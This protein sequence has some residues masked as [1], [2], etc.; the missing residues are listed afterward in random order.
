MHGEEF[1][2]KFHQEQ[3]KQHQLLNKNAGGQMGRALE[4]VWSAMREV[5]SQVRG[6]I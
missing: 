3:L 2:L 1:V 5:R 6:Q 4:I